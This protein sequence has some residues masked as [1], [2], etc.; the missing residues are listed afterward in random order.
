[1]IAASDRYSPVAFQT[2]YFNTF[3]Y[4]FMTQFKVI[5]LTLLLSMQKLYNLPLYVDLYA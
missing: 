3:A 5:D 2:L 4:L 1:L